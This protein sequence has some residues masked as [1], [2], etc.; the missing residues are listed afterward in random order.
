ME[1]L[2]VMKIE[3]KS[4]QEFLYEKHTD[5]YSVEALG[6]NIQGQMMKH[7]MKKGHMYIEFHLFS[8]FTSQ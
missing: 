5:H 4:T 3:T 2:F 7:D 1:Q 8:V 6:I